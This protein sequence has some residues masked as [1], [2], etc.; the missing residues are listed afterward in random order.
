MTQGFVPLALG[1]SIVAVSAPASSQDELGVVVEIRS[2][3]VAPKLETSSALPGQLAQQA[4]TLIAELDLMDNADL[5]ELLLT[6]EFAIEPKTTV[7]TYEI[8]HKGNRVRLDMGRNSLLGALTEDRSRIAEW[9]VID[10]ASGRVIQ[11]DAFNRAYAGEQPVTT[12]ATPPGSLR[13][14]AGPDP[15]GRTETILGHEAHGYTSTDELTMTP[16]GR[17]SGDA[18]VPGVVTRITT[19]V[20]VATEGRYAGDDELGA[21]LRLLGSGFGAGEAG[22]AVADLSSRGL[23]L[24]SD[25]RTEIFMGSAVDGAFKGGKALSSASWRVTGIERKP[26]DDSLFAGF[27]RGE[28]SCDCSCAAWREMEAMGKLS[29]DEVRNHPRVMTHAMCAPQC[30]GQWIACAQ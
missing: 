30:A 7:E 8:L 4:L 9:A 23:V 1:L 19:D 5:R 10:P 29:K 12:T 17:P 21:I 28:Q 2:E 26:L 13:R 20:W 3:S 24:G 18:P 11:T 14:I 6:R 15:T 16:L 27:E 22:N 25:Q